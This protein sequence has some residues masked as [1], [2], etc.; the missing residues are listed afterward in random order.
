MPKNPRAR[1][2]ATSPLFGRLL[3]AFLAMAFFAMVAAGV[4]LLTVSVAPQQT[5]A[6][7]SF[8]I[9]I[10]RNKIDL[11]SGVPGVMLVLIGGIGL[12][13][14]AIKTPV[15]QIVGFEEPPAAGGD[16]RLFSL[17]VTSM[18]RPI[19]GEVEHVPLLLWWLVGRK[20]AAV[21]V[22]GER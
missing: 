15:R 13:L 20:R 18:P 11:R 19:L 12:L 3:V 6:P 8:L 4:V 7:S 10:G 22:D 17:A 5:E 2:P 1:R 21:R 9:Q 14:L 16:L